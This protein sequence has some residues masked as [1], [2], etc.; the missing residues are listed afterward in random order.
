MRG[1]IVEASDETVCSSLRQCL[2]QGLS[3]LCKVFVEKFELQSFVRHRAEFCRLCIFV[4]VR[5]VL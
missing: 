2:P 5:R 3:A 1:T 4:G